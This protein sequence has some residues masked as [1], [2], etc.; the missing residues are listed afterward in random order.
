MMTT[1][2]RSHP[3]HD[4]MKPRFTLAN[5]CTQISLEKSLRDLT[6][7][8]FYYRDL[9]KQKTQLPCCSAA[10][11]ET[12]INYFASLHPNQ[13]LLPSLTELQP[14]ANRC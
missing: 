12:A 6:V 4:T 11:A 7:K 3:S 13:T 10:N 1:S 9:N 2:T 14:S 8:L 5:P